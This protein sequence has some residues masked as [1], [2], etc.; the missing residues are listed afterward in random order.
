MAAMSGGVDSSVAAALLVEQGY[1]VIG[2]TLRLLPEKTD[3]DRALAAIGDARA[4]AEK[5]DIPHS[6][7]DYQKDFQDLV[8]APFIREYMLGRT[9]NPCVQCNRSIKFG[10]LLERAARLGI[11]YV[12]TGHYAR[13]LREGGGVRLFR[14]KDSDKDQSYALYALDQQ[15]LKRILFP[16]GDYCKT[17]IRGLAKKYGL[18]IADKPDSQEICFIPD[19]SYKDFLKASAGLRETPGKI[20]DL[21]GNV[22]GSHTG[23]YNYTI[24]QRKGLGLATGEPLYVVDINRENNTVVVGSNTEVFSRE[25]TVSDF[26]WIAGAPPGANFKAKV[27]IRY[28]APLHPA[29]ITVKEDGQVLINFARAQRAVTP[30][31]S[32]VVYQGDE[33]LGGGIISWRILG[34]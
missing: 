22:L 6:V 16:L 9:P 26:N 19:K 31:Q 11:E 17:E 2:V 28:N 33:V 8:I 3:G 18:K 5:L 7:I 21:K 25:F 23:I 30:G 4:V 29:L 1:E 34:N 14:G 32:A 13:I 27:M 12:A 24:G 10:R 20:V 15:A